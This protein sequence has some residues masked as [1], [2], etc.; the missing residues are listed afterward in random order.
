MRENPMHKKLRLLPGLTARTIGAPAGY[1]ELIGGTPEDV[2]F[3]SSAS[4]EVDFIH[5]FVNNLAELKAKIEDT[6]KSVKYDGLLWISYPKGS[7]KIETDIN[8]DIIWDD[9]KSHGIRPVTQVS[10]NEIWSAI[11]F[12]PTDA[13]GK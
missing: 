13:V 6:L 4:N 7:S 11:R 2:Q 9:L 12:R 8:R 10:L 3:L 5:L 1:F